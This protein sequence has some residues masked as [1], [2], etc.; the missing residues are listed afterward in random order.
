MPLVHAGEREEPVRDD[1]HA[2][3]RKVRPQCAQG[4]LV[5]VTGGRNQADSELIQGLLLDQGIPSILRRT[6]GFDVPDMLAA[7]PRDVMVPAAGYEAAR[8]MLAEEGMLR[9][10]PEPGSLPGIGSPL[11]LALWIGGAVAIGFLIVVLL[12]L[13][14]S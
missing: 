12:D 14:A 2:K 5:K 9:P 1:A 7:G 3:A 8:R 13:V 4:D 10:E 6:R 11:R